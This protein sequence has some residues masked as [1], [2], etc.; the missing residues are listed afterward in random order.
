MLSTKKIY[1]EECWY[2]FELKIEKENSIQLFW[3]LN[4]ENTP[5]LKCRFAENRTCVPQ[6][7][8]LLIL[9]VLLNVLYRKWPSN[10]LK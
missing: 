5:I 7:G 10:S 3:Y 6:D 9:S 2:T 8:S 4:Y 1:A